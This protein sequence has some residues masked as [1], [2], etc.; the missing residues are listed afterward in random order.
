MTREVPLHSLQFVLM[1]ARAAENRL[2]IF[3]TFASSGIKTV[4]CCPGMHSDSS[5]SLLYVL[6]SSVLK[7]IIFCSQKLLDQQ[8]KQFF[9]PNER[10]SALLVDSGKISTDGG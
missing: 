9:G 1:Q 7:Y 3:D 2:L 6:K 10:L 4:S 8:L 5:F